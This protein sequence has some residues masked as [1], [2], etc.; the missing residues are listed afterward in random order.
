MRILV[1]A[2]VFLLLA[3]SAG[4][5]RIAGT[6]RADRLAGTPRNDTILGLDG[7][8]RITGAA[9][10]DFLSGGGGR[11]TID[12]G[13][14]ADRVV[15][16]YDGS[17]DMVRCGSGADLVN[18]DLVD[19][20]S[21][22]CE[23][24]S[25]RLSRDPY[26]TTDAQ[27]ETQV[28]PDS[29]T[30]G[31]VTVATYQVGRRFDGGAT[32]IGW[33][34]S[35]DDGR[36]WRSGLLPA[37]TL[38]SV[39]A[40]PHGRASDPV[41]AYDAAARV[42]LISTLA[43]EG[44]T[45]RLMIHRS[46]DGLTWGAPVTAAAATFA[47]G[48][49]FDK[50]WIACDN[51]AASPFRGSCYLA[52]TDTQR[53]D[54]IAVATSRDGGL[55]WSAPVGIPVTNAVGAFPVLRP[56]GDLVVIFLWEVA[57]IGSSVS[58]DG[59][60]TFGQPVTVADLDV[61]PARGLRFFPLP[62]ADVAPSGRVWATWH[63]CRFSAGCAA[64]SVVVSTSADGISWSAPRRITRGRNAMLPAVGIHPVS[65]RA[66]FVYHVVRPAG[67]DVE[68]VEARPGGGAARAAAPPL[69]ADD[70]DELDPEHELGP[71]ARR[72]HLGALRGRA[73]AR[74]VGARS[75]RRA[76]SGRR[77][78][79]PAAE[80]QRLSEPDRV[81]DRLRLE[82]AVDLP[83][84]LRVGR[85]ADDALDVLR[86]EPHEVGRVAVRAGEVDRVHVHVPGEP[87]RE[88]V[89]RAGEDVDRARGDVGGRER[90]GEL[91][92][93]ERVLLG[94]DRDDGVAA[95]ERRDDAADE[96]AERRLVR[97]ERRD[98][99]G[100][101]G[102]AEVEV[103]PGDGVRAAEHLRE[104]VRPARVPDRRDRPRRRPR[105]R[106]STRARGRSRAPP[107]SRRAGRGPG[108]GCRRSRPP[109]RGRPRGRL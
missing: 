45:T 80:A 13:R 59:G 10:A 84:A 3:G 24:V 16:Q 70:A 29:L 73:A 55:T 100:R 2:L 107:S 69:G 39:P 54:R 67:I 17:R 19:A 53:G 7:R 4:A 64:N 89:A 105:P 92:R 93:R 20:V 71:H 47:G 86:R 106:R 74:G 48:I 63:D 5:A 72:L 78:T 85:R 51:G 6:E 40:G 75:S 98:Y 30:V 94:G 43:I 101:L 21:G 46:S 68:L 50:N 108:R 12:A 62:S 41:V 95:D 61:R 14:G 91:D 38:A 102:D 49:T 66:A 87:G 83:R 9:G 11:D 88:L 33:S 81:P 97:R 76:R 34:T 35:R 23:V 58:T 90:L 22:D 52:Y 27:H 31:R 65:G 26:T 8:D 96:A 104:L 44:A 77:S 56:D 28:E 36:T 82:E 57:R 15:A 99:A 42:W 25:R 32:N 109:S 37:L 79:R 18:A 60:T 103:R 1:A